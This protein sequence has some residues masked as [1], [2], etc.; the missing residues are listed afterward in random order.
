[1]SKRLEYVERKKIPLS[2]YSPNVRLDKLSTSKMAPAVVTIDEN[3]REANKNKRLGLGCSLSS[4]VLD[5]ELK[6]K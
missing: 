3:Q 1:M 4:S 2:A 6:E 5:Y